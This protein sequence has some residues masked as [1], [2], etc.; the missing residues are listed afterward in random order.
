[1]IAQL[2]FLWNRKLHYPFHK[3]GQSMMEIFF[4]RVFRL[5]VGF[6]CCSI[7]VRSSVTLATGSVIHTHTRILRRKSTISFVMSVRPFALDGFS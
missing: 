3:S 1:M 2:V 4:L 5:S 6:D 7:L